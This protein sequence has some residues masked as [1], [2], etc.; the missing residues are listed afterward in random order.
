MVKK[1]RF[2][3]W[4]LEVD[5]DKTRDFFTKHDIGDDCSCS[6]CRNYRLNC[7]N[8]SGRLAAFFQELGVDAR[9]EGEFI[10]FGPNDQGNIHYMGFYHVVGR[11]IEGPTKITDRW[12]QIDLFKIDNYE[13]GFSSEDIACVH[14]G[15]P[16]PVI[17]LEFSTYLPWRLRT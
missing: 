11:I 13:F 10:D 3:D 15:F 4:M 1:L 9:K 8:M 14:E 5:T 16:E 12:D 7:E 2:N 17:Q 6:S